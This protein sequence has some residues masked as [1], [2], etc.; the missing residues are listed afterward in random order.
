MTGNPGGERLS[1]HFGDF[2]SPQDALGVTRREPPRGGR[3]DLLQLAGQ[4]LQSLLVQ[5][6]PELLP[7]RGIA[8]RSRADPLEE[9]PQ[10]EAASAHDERQPAAR[11]DL[12]DG[13]AGPPRE[14]PGRVS[15]MGLQ[16]V[17][18]VVRD[19]RPLLRPRLGR[20]DVEPPV[21]LER[22]GA[23]DLAAELLGQ[24]H[25]QV[26]LARGR[27]AD[28]GEEGGG[29]RAQVA[30]FPASEATAAIRSAGSIGLGR[31]IWNPA[32]RALTRSSARA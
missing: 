22:I 2:E 12:V 26:A 11:L 24:G 23:D 25:R 6:L 29:G 4:H 9:R 1:A 21:G 20:A 5:A 17:D 31:C 18:Q 28:N 16:D 3:I 14:L 8:R 32:A 10:V 27:G 19:P 30:A 13:L 7:Y 15:L